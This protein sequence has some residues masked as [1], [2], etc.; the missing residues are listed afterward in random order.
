[1]KKLCFLLVII[2]CNSCKSSDDA[3]NLRFAYNENYKI[4]KNEKTV[5]LNKNI[6]QEYDNLMGDLKVN[7]PLN[8]YVYAPDYKVYIGV[9]MGN[10][11]IEVANAF[12]EDQNLKIISSKKIK[13]YYN[14]FCK[15]DKNFMVKIL[16]SEKKEKLPVVLNLVSQDSILIKKIYDEDILIKK[17]K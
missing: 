6:I 3:S 9:C 10:S 7:I 14:L 4:D 13:N 12:N 2:L 5:P 8:K 17:I 16:Y 11:L 15:K 1:M